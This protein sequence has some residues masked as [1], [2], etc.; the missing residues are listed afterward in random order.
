MP[1]QQRYA[2]DHFDETAQQYARDLREAG[3][4]RA[5][6]LR[7]DMI[8]AAMPLAERLARRYRRG[9]EPLADLEQVARLGLVKAVDRYDPERGSFTAYAINTVSGE[10]KRHLRDSTWVVHVPRRMQ[11][12]A[13]A[14]TQQETLL[15]RDLGRH[16]SETELA[17]A[18][19]IDADDLGKARISA[20]GYRPLSLNVPVGEGDTQFGDMLGDLDSDL[21]QAA[22][23]LTVTELVA[24]L[25]E[26]ER[27]IVVQ[28]FY[29]GRTQSA[30]AADLGI[31]QMHVSRTLAR[32]LAW[33][34]EG[35]LTD[36][37]PRW[38]AGHEPADIPFQV[39]TRWLP[40]G[41]LEIAVAGEV[42]RDNA[43]HLRTALLDLTRHQ[44]A[45][46]RVILQL[47]R[48]PLLDAAGIRVLLGVYE[49]ARA[50][51]IAVTAAGLTP[52]V[53]QIAGAAGLTPMLASEEP[54]G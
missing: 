9:S 31:S 47:S 11:E 38:P 25:P 40:G 36:Q 21:E 32:V 6:R 52:F 42:D 27:H 24:S 4:A 50:R 53:R 8:S 20:T 22:D 49:S 34:R 37:V 2:P 43:G 14:V 39:V 33:L 23:R 54:A 10:L 35:L 48:V 51:G 45:G 17:A 7:D 30:V 15:T 29:G 16:P 12:L 46:R 13:L 41:E 26:R 1:Q 44:P 5:R 18:C 28:I 19:G 3:G